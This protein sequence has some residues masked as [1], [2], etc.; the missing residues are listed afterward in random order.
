MSPA[1]AAQVMVLTSRLTMT[2]GTTPPSAHHGDQTV[3]QPMIAIAHGRFPAAI[4]GA[5]TPDARF[6]GVIVPS[7]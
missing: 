2:H 6:T 7:P 5:G 4:G 1:Q 3:D